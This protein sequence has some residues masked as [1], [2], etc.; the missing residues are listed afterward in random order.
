MEVEV[1][2]LEEAVLDAQDIAAGL[3][4]SAKIQ[5]LIERREECR[6]GFTDRELPREVRV[7]ALREAKEINQQLALVA[8]LREVNEGIEA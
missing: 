6:I 1:T 7:E 2:M 8:T 3:A 4:L 5:E